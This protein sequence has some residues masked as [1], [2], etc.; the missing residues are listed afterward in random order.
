MSGETLLQEKN[1]TAIG[2]TRTRVLAD[3]IAIAVSGLNFKAY[4]CIILKETYRHVAC[5]VAHV[6]EVQ[7]LV[8]RGG[9]ILV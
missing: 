3:S 1:F 6:P 2:G 4:R 9:C 7:C 5:S 8:V